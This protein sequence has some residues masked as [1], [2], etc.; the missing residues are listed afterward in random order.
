MLFPLEIIL[1]I[2]KK[3]E[4]PWLYLLS[5]YYNLT[6]LMEMNFFSNSRFY[7]QD[8]LSIK[9][10]KYYIRILL[11][12]NEYLEELEKNF[13]NLEEENN[14]SQDGEESMNWKTAE[15]KKY[16]ICLDTFYIKD[17]YS[18]SR[19]KEVYKAINDNYFKVIHSYIYQL[20]YTKDF[21]E[22][23]KIHKNNNQELINIISIIMGHIQILIII[24]LIMVS[25]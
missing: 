4:N 3:S 23:A 17:L 20:G 10:F 9:Y 25:Q 5:G 7:M 15:N 12:I 2:C 24:L 19:D 6:D 14:I 11:V 1:R 16:K 18:E 13:N 22:Y 21:L 8:L